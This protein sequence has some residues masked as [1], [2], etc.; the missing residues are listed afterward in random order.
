MWLFLW[1]DTPGTR[2]AKCNETFIVRVREK[3]VPQRERM[4]NNRYIL[5]FGGINYS[6]LNM[7]ESLGATLLNVAAVGEAGD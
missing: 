6:Y 7:K 3:E 2:S 5:K 1:P 4:L